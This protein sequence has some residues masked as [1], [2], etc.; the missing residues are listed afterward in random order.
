MRVESTARMLPPGSS[1]KLES[2]RAEVE[3]PGVVSYVPYVTI[4]ALEER[5]SVRSKIGWGVW[6]FLFGSAHDVTVPCL[7][8]KSLGNA[9]TARLGSGRGQGLHPGTEALVT[10]DDRRMNTTTC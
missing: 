5:A 9:M 2:S 4:I 3:L 6:W 10:Q 8:R 7:A 1:K